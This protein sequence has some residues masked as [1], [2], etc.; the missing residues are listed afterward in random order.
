MKRLPPHVE[1]PWLLPQN[2]AFYK[3]LEVNLRGG[4]VQGRRGHDG[5]R[6]EPVLVIESAIVGASR[7]PVV[8]PRLRFSVRD[9]QGAAIYA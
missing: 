2:A 7:K 5:N 3:L 4:R 6:G 8:P 9:A 1:S